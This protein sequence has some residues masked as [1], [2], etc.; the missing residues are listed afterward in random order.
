MLREQD[1]F[2]DHP[3]QVGVRNDFI[4]H[5]D[6]VIVLVCQ[7]NGF[8]GETGKKPPVGNAAGTVYLNIERNRLTDSLLLVLVREKA[9]DE[10]ITR[11]KTGRIF[12][13]L[14]RNI[15]KTDSLNLSFHSAGSG[16]DRCVF[17]DI[18]LQEFPYRDA[19]RS[20]PHLS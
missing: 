9:S 13:L 20:R 17:Q 16:D 15:G 3:N 12:P 8:L 18:D 11:L 19:H 1:I 4:Q 6:G 7:R 14:Q 5:N 10:H 2:C